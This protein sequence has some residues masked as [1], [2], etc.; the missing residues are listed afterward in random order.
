MV[1]KKLSERIDIDTWK[2][3][4][5]RAQMLNIYDFSD[6][7]FYD[8]LNMMRRML[9]DLDI[10]LDFLSRYPDNISEVGLASLLQ[11]IYSGN[12]YNDYKKANF[13]EKIYQ[14][15]ELGIPWIQ[16]RPVEFPSKVEGISLI[17]DSDEKDIIGVNKCFTDGDFD[18]GYPDSPLNRRYDI[19]NL[20]DANYLINILLSVDTDYKNQF[21]Y[22]DDAC[23]VLKNFNG[24]YPSKE[25]ITEVRYPGLCMY[26]N[27]NKNI[28]RHYILKQIFYKFDPRE[29][30][31]TKRLV[32]TPNNYHYE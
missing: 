21:V 18:I 15:D 2:V 4:A 13:Y 7:E 9:S 22:L 30:R 20:N 1:L 10:S 16:F 29:A 6:E 8:N 11:A 17:K 3:I 28:K 31:Y 5:D 26:R 25:S 19:E 14:L 24:E 12:V 27:E 23:A 32:R